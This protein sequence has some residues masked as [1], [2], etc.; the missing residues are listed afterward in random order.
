MRV[1]VPGKRGARSRMG[2]GHHRAHC[3]DGGS[4]DISF[5]LIGGADGRVAPAVAERIRPGDERPSQGVSQGGTGGGAVRS[6]PVRLR[7]LGPTV[8]PLT[9]ERRDR[10]GS[11][12]DP[13]KAVA[14]GQYFDSDHMG[15]A[16]RKRACNSPAA[17][18]W[19]WV[20]AAK[21]RRP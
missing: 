15:S 12:F 10:T 14:G 19:S 17:K 7:A 2:F 5:G 3:R 13:F 9:C 18:A 16:P 21:V 6:S 8:V 20:L 11:L 4:S 1:C